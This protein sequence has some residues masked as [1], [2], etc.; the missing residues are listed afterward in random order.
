M[1][2][3]ITSSRMMSHSARAQIASASAPLDA[4]RTSKYSADSRAS[5]SLTLAGTSSTP[6]MRADIEIPLPDKPPDGFNKF[7]DRDRL[8]TQCR[9]PASADPFPVPLLHADLPY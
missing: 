2:G 8:G 1:S 9:P 6:R 4:V 3:I 5:K 7:A